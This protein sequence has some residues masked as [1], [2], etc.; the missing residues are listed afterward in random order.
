MSDLPINSVFAG[1]RIERLLG[2]GGMGTVYLARNPDL[3]RSEAIKV[4]SVQLSSD[5]AFRA[6]FVREA[7]VAAALDHPNIVSVHQRGEFDG[8]LWIAMQYVEGTDADAAQRAGTMNPQRAV[9]T[10]SEVAKALDYAHH[11]GVVH[12]DIKPA[13][14]LLSESVGGEERVLLADFGIARALGDVGLTSTGSVMATLAFAAPEVLSGTDFDGRADLYSLGCS[15]FRLLTGK[16]PYFQ[17]DGAA[18]VMAAHLN[19]PPPRVTEVAPWLS[20]QMD[21]VIAKAMA[22]DPAQRFASA[23]ELAEA[24]LQALAGTDAA[25]QQ[26]TET[27][28][29]YPRHPTGAP[30]QLS[31]TPQPAYVMPQPARSRGKLPAAMA[32]AAVVVLLGGG[33]AAWALT[34]RS[35]PPLPASTSAG[36]SQPTSTSSTPVPNA[37]LSGLLLP[38]E[39]A[40]ELVGVPELI[41]DRTLTAIQD[42]S[43]GAVDLKECVSALR[44]AQHLAYEALDWKAAVE[45]ILVPPTGVGAIVVQAVIAFPD[46]A[47]AQK[48]LRNERLIWRQCA[49]KTLMATSNAT[50]TAHTFSSVESVDDNTV[51]LLVNRPDGFDCQRALGVRNNVVVDVMACR[52]GVVHQA[53]EILQKIAG[54]IPA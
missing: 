5:P 47:A 16:S 17:A 35:E 20:P 28:T 23:R 2:V 45:Q 51:A 32:V 10:I 12:R 43:S 4:L 13:N 52:T 36:T 50:T 6:R 3:P 15:L 19:Q 11:R 39:Q 44:P 38:T 30:T 21:W 41:V 25:P 29:W 27:A 37:A 46:A 33:V 18:A 7:D 24:A 1:Y 14:F 22:K 31:H 54:R 42:D 8:Q 34:S 48:L 49:G 9:R 40:A 53:A 26:P